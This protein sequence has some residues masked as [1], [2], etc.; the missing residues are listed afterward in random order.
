M[1]DDELTNDLIATIAAGAITEACGG[2][3]GIAMAGGV[4]VRRG[5]QIRD[6]DRGNPLF[7]AAEIIRKARDPWAAV[8]L[9][10]ALAV[11][12][13]LQAIHGPLSEAKVRRLWL[14]TMDE[15]AVT[16]GDEDVVASR[17]HLS[18]C[19][20]LPDLYAAD[21]SH[22]RPLLRRLALNL[23]CQ[24]HGWDPRPVASEGVN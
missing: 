24:R 7:R 12:R 14:D 4:S 23:I 8:R 2:P 15:E 5:R 16:D 11:E 10:I 22:V 3:K 9:F 17:F 18:R 13:E 6:G 20:S 21:A 1:R 19:K